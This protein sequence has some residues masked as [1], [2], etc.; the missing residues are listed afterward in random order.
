M[1]NSPS[2]QQLNA[3]QL[4]GHLHCPHFIVLHG[5]A[6]NLEIIR[7]L[8]ELLT[9]LGQIHLL[10][11]PGF[12]KSPAPESTWGTE[13]YANCVKSYLD[14]HQIESAIFV[15]H[16]FGGKTSLK[17]ASINPER[18]KALVLINSSGLKGKPPLSRRIKIS[19][20][21][22]LRTV[23]RFLQNRFNI[24]LYETW[25]IPR[26]SSPDY[27][28]AGP[29]KSTFVK[30]VNEELSEEIAGISAPALCLWGDQDTET[31]LEMGRRMS[32]LLKNGRLVV[33]E[34]Q[35]HTPFSGPGAAVCAF[36]IK[37]FIRA[38]D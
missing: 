3:L 20:V 7:P 11:L 22:T 14:S 30:V 2:Y 37:E 34:G 36:H 9:G 27:K 10:D 29:L 25:F 31:P 28:N 18:V 21:K 13:D 16:S 35:G 38:L 33:L 4:P 17:L 23:L 26:F 24:K 32:E 8:A 15:G 1:S 19:Y 5:W 6:H 12:G